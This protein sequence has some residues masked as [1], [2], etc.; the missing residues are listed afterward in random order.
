MS[1]KNESFQI[2]LDDTFAKM[3]EEVKEYVNLTVTPALQ[4]K[5]VGVCGPCLVF[6]EESRLYFI[7]PLFN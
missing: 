6:L 1:N 2:V 4:L 3:N 5:D 7:Y